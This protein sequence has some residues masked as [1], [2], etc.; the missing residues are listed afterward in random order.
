VLKATGL[1]KVPTRDK[2]NEYMRY[3]LRLKPFW[4]LSSPEILAFETFQEAFSVGDTVPEY[5]DCLKQAHQAVFVVRNTI[6]LINRMDIEQV[7]MRFCSKEYKEVFLPSGAQA[8]D[9]ELR[10]LTKS[11]I[12][13][14]IFIEALGKL[15]VQGRD[16]WAKKMVKTEKK[17]HP[18]FSVISI[19]DKRSRSTG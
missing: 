13:L 6:D 2:T 14:S 3:T 12:G 7:N 9:K 15:V 19:V 8:D 1:T 17:Y 16:E 4:G 10:N 11:C 5:M 18:Y